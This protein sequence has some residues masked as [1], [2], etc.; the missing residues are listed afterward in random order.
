MF[1][2]LN[3]HKVKGHSGDYGNNSADKLAVIGRN[4]GAEQ[5]WRSL[6]ETE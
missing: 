6:D 2:N 5:E 1:H 3:V 4:L